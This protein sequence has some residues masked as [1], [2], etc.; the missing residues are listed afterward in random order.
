MEFTAH[1]VAGFLNGSVEGD[2]EIK[3]HQLSKIEEGQPGTL[4]FLANPKYTQFIYTT[5][6]SVVVVSKDFVAQQPVKATLI[7]VEDAYQSFAT[8]LRMFDQSRPEPAGIKSTAIIDSSAKIGAGSTVSDLAYIGKN[9]VLGENVYIYPQVFLG[10]DVTVGNGTIIYPGARVYHHCVIGKQCILHAGVIVGS[11][12]FG[13]APV[14]GKGF[15]KIPQLGNVVIE[16]FVEIG[17]N[18]TIDRATMGS[19][20]LREGVK[21][22]NLIQIAHNV[23]IGSHTVIAAQ[24]GISGSTKIGKRCMIGG[25]VGI[26]GHLTIADDVKIGAGSGIEGNITIPGTIMLGSPAAEAS[27]TRRNFVHFRNLDNIVKKLYA[28]EKKINNSSL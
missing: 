25:Q 24:T 13:F 16:D 6:A 28:I 7:R 27:K 17:S 14:E 12:G 23:E 1:Q 8:L 20:I 15:Q 21:L 9:V 19:T 22:D 3:I 4:S 11:D 18:T 10:D 2:P 26:V 5:L